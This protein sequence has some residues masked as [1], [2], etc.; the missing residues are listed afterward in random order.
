MK[1]TKNDIDCVLMSLDIP[2]ELYRCGLMFEDTKKS[3]DGSLRGFDYYFFRE[4]EYIGDAIV[5]VASRYRELALY[6]NRCSDLHNVVSVEIDFTTIK[7]YRK[8]HK[9]VW[10][11]ELISTV[12]RISVRDNNSISIEF[13]EEFTKQY[14]GYIVDAKLLHDSIED[15][16]LAG[17]GEIVPF[18]MCDGYGEWCRLLDNVVDGIKRLL[19]N[20][21]RIY[22]DFMTNPDVADALG[23]RCDGMVRSRYHDYLGDRLF[24][25]TTVYVASGSIDTLFVDPVNGYDI[26]DGDVNYCTVDA[27]HMNI[28]DIHSDSDINRFLDILEMMAYS[29][30][31][32]IQYLK[33]S[34]E[35]LGREVSGSLYMPYRKGV[36]DFTDRFSDFVEGIYRP[37]YNGVTDGVCVCSIDDFSEAWKFRFSLP[38]R[39]LS[40]R[41]MASRVSCGVAWF[42]TYLYMLHLY[43]KKVFGVDIGR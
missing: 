31:S 40:K 7:R 24:V 19:S 9:E 38:V 11:Q 2:Y 12:E 22:L 4:T 35:L 26:D 28:R 43:A 29:N 10:F 37:S 32:L 42:D 6:H 15:T 39:L 16:M 17:E 14:M 34:Y 41:L 13:T 27:N 33:S 36:H 30:D 18:S 5:S 1:V 8:Y 21:Y 3:E 25:K 20:A 23:R